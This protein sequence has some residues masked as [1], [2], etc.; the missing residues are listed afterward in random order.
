MSIWWMV[1]VFLVGG[2]AGILLHALLAMAARRDEVAARMRDTLDD[3]GISPL[4][5]V[6][7]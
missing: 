2:Y 4:H 3:A 5:A 1:G 6:T 7:R